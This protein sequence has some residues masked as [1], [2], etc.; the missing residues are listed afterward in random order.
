MRKIVLLMFAVMLGEVLMSCAVEVAD[1]GAEIGTVTQ[2]VSNWHSL[3]QNARNQAIV[4][5]VAN[6]STGDDGGQC[7]T[8]VQLNVVPNASGLSGLIP[9]N[10][11]DVCY[12]NYGQYVQGRSQSISSALPGEIVQMRLSGGGPHTLI[13]LAIGG[14]YIYVAESN[15]S[16]AYQE[17]VGFR[18]LTLSQFESMTSCYTIYKVL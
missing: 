9:T 3:S 15:W 7:K 11:S 17:K 13:V 18:W 6:W 14:G 12:W 1:E 16:P 10:S 4:D 8:W 2:A 5:E